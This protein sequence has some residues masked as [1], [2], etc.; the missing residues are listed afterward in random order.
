MAWLCQKT[1]LTLLPPIAMFNDLPLIALDAHHYR[2]QDKYD[3]N[4]V[5]VQQQHTVQIIQLVEG[6]PPPP[7]NLAS[8]INS[9]SSSYVSSSSY[10]D[11]WDDDD[12]Q[13]EEEEICESYCSSEE[14][15]TQET[16]ASTTDTYSLR[17]KRILAWRE[18]FSAHLSA[19]L[20]GEHHLFVKQLKLIHFVPEPTLPSS[21]KR[22][23]SF[24][25]DIVRCLFT[26]LFIPSDP[27]NVVI[28]RHHNHQN[29]HDPSPRQA[30]LPWV[31]IHAL[32]VMHP[33]TQNKV[34]DNMVPTLRPTRL[35]PLP[36]N[37]HLNERNVL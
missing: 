11:S 30:Y 26:Y 31:F 28:R 9:S 35:A 19:T 5:Y 8:V 23:L 34:Y 3:D 24:D 18:N 7:R 20:S 1:L 36:W 14:E 12:Q 17:M 33:L 2:Q 13:D 15:E 4:L 10:S 22:K 27:E 37:M 16:P 29:V 32:R 6:P 25:D 21:L